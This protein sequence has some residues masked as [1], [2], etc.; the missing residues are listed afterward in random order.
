MTAFS[1]GLEDIP[2][3]TPEGVSLAEGLAI[4]KPVRGKRILQALRESGGGALTVTEDEIKSAWQALAQYSLVRRI[5]ERSGSCGP[6]ASLYIYRRKS[7]SGCRVDRQR[8]EI[9][10]ERVNHGK[11]NCFYPRHTAD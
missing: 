2:E 3:I 5:H 6:A 7:E 9:S 8:P 10:A 11:N 1:A 4:V